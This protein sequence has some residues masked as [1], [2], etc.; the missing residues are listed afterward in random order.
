VKVEYQFT[1]AIFFRVVGEYDLA[2]HDDLRDETRT[3][4]PLIIGGRKALATRSAQFHTDLLFSYQP[5]P[6]TVLFVGY[7]GLA[8]APPNPLERFNFQP[9]V[10]SSDYV[11]AKFSYLFRL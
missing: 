1:R 3:F 6:G 2:E 8:N 5:S 4:L 11:F 7:G 10:R 9:L